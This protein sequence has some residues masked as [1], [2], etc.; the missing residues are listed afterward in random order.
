[1]QVR[2][3]D[4]LEEVA[5]LITT[6]P[7]LHTS[8]LSKQ[9][10]CEVGTCSMQHVHGTFPAALATLLVCSSSTTANNTWSAVPHMT[11]K[12]EFLNLGASVK[13]RIVLSFRNMAIDAG[14]LALD[15]PTTEGITDGTS[16]PPHTSPLF[17]LAPGHEAH[18]RQ[19][20]VEEVR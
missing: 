19:T 9:T 16:C 14:D 4:L 7:L 10:G 3:Q 13:C 11:A 1:M 17:W 5:G 12:A 2:Q 15:G 8:S 18:W 20:V 6:T